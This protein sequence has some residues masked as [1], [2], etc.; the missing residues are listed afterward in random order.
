MI[1]V[2]AGP[3]PGFE[4]VTDDLQ[5][6]SPTARS[7]SSNSP[8]NSSFCTSRPWPPTPTAR[9]LSRARHH[10]RSRR[11]M[12]AAKR[13]SITSRITACAR[14]PTSSRPRPTSSIRAAEH[15]PLRRRLAG[16]HAL[17][18]LLVALERD[19]AD[20]RLRL[21]LDP[22][23]GLGRA[24]P[25]GEQEVALAADLRAAALNSS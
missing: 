13:S 18:R 16:Q 7:R 5:A 11:A 21:V 15:H 23:L 1:L 25:V 6:T 8:A 17:A 4:V 22:L 24:V 9:Q 20:G 14:R 10:A 12:A 3:P 19:A 2:T